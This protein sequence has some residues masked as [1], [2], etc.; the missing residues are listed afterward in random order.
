[1]IQ[2]LH[3]GY[4]YTH[5]N[6]FRMKIGEG[7]HWLIINTLSPA[8]FFIDGEWVTCEKNAIIIYAPGIFVDYRAHN[9]EYK[10]NYVLFTTDNNFIVN[11]TCPLGKPITVLSQFVFDYIFHMLSIDSNFESKNQGNN[12]LLL[13]RLLFN[14]IEEQFVDS[15]MNIIGSRTNNYVF[16]LNLLNTNILE[17]PSYN[18]TVEYMASQLN[19]CKGHFQKIYKKQ[20]GI[21]CMEFVYRSRIDLAKTYLCM[22]TQRIKDVASICGY[23]NSEHFSRHFKRYTQMS[24]QEY[25]ELHKNHKT[26]E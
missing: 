5:S 11:T 7:K 13:Y 10:N 17:N 23:N 16:Q 6:D 21:S 2:T 3:V 24:P 19:L 4:H 15:S 8:D 1:M 26:K 18:W 12:L 9:T 14:K 22:A 20:F 25:R